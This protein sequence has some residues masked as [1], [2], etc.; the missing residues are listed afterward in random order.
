MRLLIAALLAAALLRDFEVAGDA[1][2]ILDVFLKAIDKLA[3][4]DK[5]QDTKVR[6]L[7]VRLSFSCANANG[8]LGEAQP[9]EK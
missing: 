7:K 9:E 1:D 4:P 2:K 3:P 8:V 5:V 6:E